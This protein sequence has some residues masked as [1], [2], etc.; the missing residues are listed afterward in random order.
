[1]KKKLLLLALILIPLQSNA[2]ELYCSSNKLESTTMIIIITA[3]GVKIIP[4][5]LKK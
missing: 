5:E 4:K 3:D 2:L 1:M